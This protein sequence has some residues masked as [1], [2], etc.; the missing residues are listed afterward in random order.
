MERAQFLFSQ[1]GFEAGENLFFL[2][3]HVVV[4]T[5]AEGGE[6]VGQGAPLGECRFQVVEG[7]A[8]GGVVSQHAHYGQVAV[9]RDVASVGGQQDFLFFPEVLPAGLFPEANQAARRAAESG[10]ALVARERSGAA[11]EQ[12]LHQYVMV[13]LAERVQARVPLQRAGCRPTSAPGCAGK[14]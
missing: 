8:D 10:G 4:E 7:G 12:S 14:R 3:P 5:S 9:E 13:M 6:R 11:H 2:Q 1:G